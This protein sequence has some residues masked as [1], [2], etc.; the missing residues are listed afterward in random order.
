M[1]PASSGGHHSVLPPRSAAEC[2]AAAGKSAWSPGA[3]TQSRAFLDGPC[4]CETVGRVSAPH[5]TQQHPWGCADAQF[6]LRTNLAGNDTD[7]GDQYF[8]I[9]A[10]RELSSRT[11]A[12]AA[13]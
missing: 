9:A 7:N 3:R 10:G 6:C 2:S 5:D 12:K 11:A 4:L 8:G 1:A 13:R